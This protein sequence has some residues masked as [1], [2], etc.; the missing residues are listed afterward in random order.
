MVEPDRTNHDHNLLA[1]MKANDPEKYQEF[2]A[3][4]RK[5]FQANK[6]Q[7]KKYHSTLQHWKGK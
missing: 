2:L 5:Y 6:E 3:N 4:A 7:M 1:E